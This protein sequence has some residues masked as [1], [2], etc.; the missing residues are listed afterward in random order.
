MREYRLHAVNRAFL[1]KATCNMCGEV[2]DVNANCEEDWQMESV[3]EFKA[4]FGYGSNHDTENWKFD[5]C[6][7]CIEK[8]VS[9]FKIAPEVHHYL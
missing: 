4:H 6:E 9:Q 5:L 7:K 8:I 1:D 3:K 2:Y